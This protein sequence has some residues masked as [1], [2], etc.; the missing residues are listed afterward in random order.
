MCQYAGRNP[1]SSSVLSSDYITVNIWQRRFFGGRIAM[2]FSIQNM[3]EMKAIPLAI[4]LPPVVNTAAFI[5]WL[6]REKDIVALGFG[7]G[8][9]Q[10]IVLWIRWKQQRYNSHG[11][12]NEMTLLKFTEP[13]TTIVWISYHW[14]WPCSN[15]KNLL[16][17]FQVYA[18]LSE[19]VKSMKVFIQP[20]EWRCPNHTKNVGPR[21]VCPKTQLYANK[22][23]WFWLYRIYNLLLQ[24]QYNQNNWEWMAEKIYYWLY[25]IL[26]FKP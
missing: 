8:W 2:T 6:Q 22:I 5:L 19:N 24:L 16:N 25:F 26:V 1:H 3:L 21:V 11:V 13:R 9:F 12:T 23:Y 4:Y 14:Q 18:G 17:I 15:G 7:P 20:T 10:K